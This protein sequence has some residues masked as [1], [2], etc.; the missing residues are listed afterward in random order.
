MPMFIQRFAFE[1]LPFSGR[2]LNRS[3]E[4]IG[5]TPPPPLPNFSKFDWLNLTV[6]NGIVQPGAPASILAPDRVYTMKH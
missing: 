1:V 4:I 2:S 6:D 5:V 3:I